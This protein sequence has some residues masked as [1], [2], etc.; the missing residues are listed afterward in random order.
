VTVTNAE[1]QQIMAELNNNHFERQDAVHSAVL[2]LLSQ[3]HLFFLGEPG[4]SKSALCRDLAMRLDGASYFETLLSRTR[5]AEAVLGPLD[6]P[7]LRDTGAFQRKREG[8]LLTADIAFLDEVG[9]MSPTLGHDIHAA[10]NERIYHEVGETGKST[11]N[12]PLSTAFTAGN[13]IPTEESDDARALWDRIVLRCKVDYI[14]NGTAFARLFET[15]DNVDPTTVDWASLRDVIENEIPQ[16]PIPSRVTDLLWEIREELK[17]HQDVSNGEGIVLSDRRWKACANVMRAQ[18]WLEGRD[19][20][21]EKDLLVL[22][23][24][25]WNETHQIEPVERV[26]IRFADKVSDQVRTLRDNI[27][28]LA[29]GISERKNHSKEQR[30]DAA[31]HTL[32]KAKAIKHELLRLSTENPGHDEIKVTITQF[33]SMWE[34]MFRILLDQDPADF[35]QWMNKG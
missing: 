30:S 21:A 3:N 9:N 13:N 17:K 23:Y 11:I 16:I 8:T 7:K 4:T 1:I 27:Q 15:T 14:Q 34:D 6:L 25:L 10:L 32:R 33:K 35:D 29:K 22:K 12:I 19:Q 28:E 31:T 5:P 18:A 2:A 24:V 26:L 20:V